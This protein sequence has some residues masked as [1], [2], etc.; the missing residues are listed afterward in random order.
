[1]RAFTS[2]RQGG[3]LPAILVII[4]F[5]VAA[6]AGGWYYLRPRFES[7]PPQVKLAPNVDALSA[8][9]T[10]EIAVSDAGTGLKSVKATLSSAGGEQVLA[11]EE[12]SQP[13]RDKK[14]TLD[15]SKLTGLKEGPAVLRV[16]ARDASW[17]RGN[18]AVLEKPLTIDLTPPT[19]DLV[20]DDRYVNFAT[21]GALV[22]KASSYTATRGVKSGN[23]FF[24]GLAGQATRNPD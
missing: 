3:G 11:S 24:S 23:Y 21:A 5:I 4:L 22:F 16:S 6:V 18:E 9:S 1:M 2:D 17:W 13:V 8:A 12:Y 19:L 10:L 7:D 15:T 14:I 20:A